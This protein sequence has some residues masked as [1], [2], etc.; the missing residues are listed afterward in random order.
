M[1]L[2]NLGPNSG[3]GRAPQRI[4]ESPRGALGTKRAAKQR[5]GDVHAIMSC[6]D[7]SRLGTNGLPM[8]K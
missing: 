5:R 3:R 8:L 6:R 4:V 7:E 1:L 2:A